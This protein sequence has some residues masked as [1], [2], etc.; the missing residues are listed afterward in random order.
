MGR[1][2]GRRIGQA[3]Q[4]DAFGGGQLRR[5]L[6]E[7][8]FRRLGDAV[9]SA[10]EID[11][12]HVHLKDLLLGAVLFDVQR[13]EKFRRL[14]GKVLLLREVDV[15]CQLLG[16]GAAAFGQRAGPQVWTMATGSTPW[17]SSNRLSSTAMTASM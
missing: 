7:V 5:R 2:G 4:Q 12:I 15:L 16:Q 8:A 17:C 9:A 6:A 10:A 13:R 14:A 3:R 1:V 11:R